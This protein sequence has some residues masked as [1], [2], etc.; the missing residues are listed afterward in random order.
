MTRHAKFPERY[1]QKGK[2][3][4]AELDILKAKADLSKIMSKLKT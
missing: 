3:A 2:Q 4:S 1:D